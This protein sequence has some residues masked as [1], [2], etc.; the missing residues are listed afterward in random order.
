MIDDDDQSIVDML[1]H[2]GCYI[3]LLAHT[4]RRDA[5]SRGGTYDSNESEAGRAGSRGHP[6]DPL[7]GPHCA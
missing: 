5:G 6:H 7:S 3:L 1:K 4:I 2:H